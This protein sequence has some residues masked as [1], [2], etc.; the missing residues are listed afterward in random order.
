VRETEQEA[1]EGCGA[2]RLASDAREVSRLREAARRLAVS[3]GATVVS[4][5]L[6]EALTRAFCPVPL[7]LTDTALQLG[8]DR[9]HEADSAER[10]LRAGVDT[11]HED[12]DF[13]V[14]V[15]TNSHG[16][17]DVE[18]PY[19]KPPGQRRVLSVGDSF[20]FGYGVELDECF[21]KVAQRELGQ[22]WQVIN[23]GVPSWGTCDE[24]DF[25]Q[26]EGFRYEPDVVVLCFFWNDLLDNAL[27]G[28]YS[29]GDDGR[30]VRR[31]PV[32]QEL[33][34]RGKHTPIGGRD[35]LVADIMDRTLG[36]PPRVEASSP[37]WWASHSNLYRLARR[38]IS[39]ATMG[40]A[41]DTNTSAPEDISGHRTR[42]TCA[43]VREFISRCRERGIPVVFLVMPSKIEAGPGRERSPRADVS[44]VV[45]TALSEAVSV[46]TLTQEL[47]EAGPERVYFPHDEHI[48]RAGHDLVGRALAR[49]VKE[50]VR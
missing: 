29:V 14:R 16:L 20:A 17:R 42:L 5:L 18:I 34:S 25:L 33:V 21:A 40:T 9:L 4:L 12:T 27:R 50:V 15:T 37:S 8:D 47:R 28:S 1:S 44:E 13:R 30:P 23:A 35:Q 45:T 7:H 43:L 36:P 31:C 19:E 10:W 11:I 49:A 46:V 2:K 24:L 41:H 38:A 26:L 32:E 22:G 48:N 39:R 6:A 3:V